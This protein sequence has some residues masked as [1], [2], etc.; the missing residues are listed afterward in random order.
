V[1]NDQIVDIDVEVA[2]GKPLHDRAWELDQ[3]DTGRIVVVL[4]AFSVLL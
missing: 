3:G 1:P 4:P 2:A